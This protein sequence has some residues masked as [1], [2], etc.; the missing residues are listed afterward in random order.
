[1]KY[2]LSVFQ[3]PRG[4]MRIF[5]FIFA[6]CAL[7]TT[8]NFEV[9]VTVVEKAH[10]NSSTFDYP[11]RFGQE[12]CLKSDNTTK[13]GLSADV[14]SDARF[15]VATSVLSVLYC[16]FI[17][18]VY[19]FIDEIYT[20]KPEVPLAD[21]MLTT[22]LAIFW[23]S[24][25]AAWANGA[26]ALKQVTNP[27]LIKAQCPN[28]IQVVTS[29]FSRLNISLLFGFLNFFLWASDLWFLYKETYWFKERQPNVDGAGGSNL[30]APNI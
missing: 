26:S 25:S 7:Y 9:T 15:F 21:F 3:E 10:S 13:L 4:V 19:T 29:S 17:T 16:I 23:L 1:M 22:I 5:Q 24:G 27:T 2:D 14:S 8:L 6:I 30:N 12:V 18:A 28:L 11:F 20:S